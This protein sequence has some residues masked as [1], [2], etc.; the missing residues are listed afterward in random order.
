MPPFNQTI[1]GGLIYNDWLLIS[2]LFVCKLARFEKTNRKIDWDGNLKLPCRRVKHPFLKQF[3]RQVS[4]MRFVTL[5][6]LLDGFSTTFPNFMTHVPCRRT[7]TGGKTP[8]GFRGQKIGRKYDV[9]VAE[10]IDVSSPALGVLEVGPWNKPRKNQ[11]TRTEWVNFV[12][13]VF[14][15]LLSTTE[16]SWRI[17][18]F[19]DFRKFQRV[20]WFSDSWDDRLWILDLTPWIV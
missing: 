11:G 16:E 5:K 17:W 7:T 2:D 19:H 10:G 14:C 13:L 8:H 18:E 15:F 1:G 20:G 12:R 3:L 4:L 9:S 6:G